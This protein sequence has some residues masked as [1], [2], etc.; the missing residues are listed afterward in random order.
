MA[1]QGNMGGVRGFVRVLWV[2]VL[3]AAVAGC[4]GDDAAP[5]V[6]P[7]GGPALIDAAVA[8]DTVVRGGTIRV[9]ATVQA[10]GF[11]D[12]IPIDFYLVPEGSGDGCGE[13]RHRVLR[14]ALVP[15]DEPVTTRVR[16]A[17]HVTTIEADPAA[18]AV[19]KLTRSALV[20]LALGTGAY[21][22]AAALPGRQA[23]CVTGGRTF[24][25]EEPDAADLMHLSG[26]LANHSFRLPAAV[27][28]SGRHARPAHVLSLSEEV[29]NAGLPVSGPFE[30]GFSLSVQG[31][32]VPLTVEAPGPHGVPVVGDRY[33]F[34][35]RAGDPDGVSIG[36]DDVRGATLHIGLT[37]EAAAELEALSEDTTCDLIATI[38]PDG[39]IQ[40]MDPGN[41][42][43][44]FP[45]RFLV[46]PEAWPL[47]ADAS[48]L[49]ADAS[50]LGD[51]LNDCGSTP[52][53]PAN[54]NLVF[55]FLPTT[56]GA[57]D[58]YTSIHVHSGYQFG[59]SAEDPSY[60]GYG[61]GDVPRSAH[62][63]TAML[64]TAGEAGCDTSGTC[65]TP[66]D[67]L[68]DLT[69]AFPPAQ[70]GGQTVYATFVGHMTTLGATLF[71]TTGLPIRSEDDFSWTSKQIK[72][73]LFKVTVD[74]AGIPLHVDVGAEGQVGLSGTA[75]LSSAADQG[76]LAEAT[77][78]PY[79]Q[80]EAFGDASVDVVVVD[81]GVG[82]NL[83]LLELEPQF[84]LA[85]Q[86]FPGTKNPV[87]I[88]HDEA[89]A[90]QADM[91]V[92]LHTLD[93]DFYA[94]VK[95][96]IVGEKQVPIANWSGLTKSF[97]LIHPVDL[98]IGPVGEFLL[99]TDGSQQSTPWTVWTNQ[100]GHSYHWTGRLA[101]KAGVPYQFDL[102]NMGTVQIYPDDG[103]SGD[104]QTFTCG[105]RQECTQTVTFTKA[106]NYTLEAITNPS[107]Y[108]AGVAEV[109]WAEAGAAD[110]NGL[111]HHSLSPSMKPTDSI[112]TWYYNAAYASNP[113][114]LG[115]PVLYQMADETEVHLHAKGSPN[116]G[117][118]NAPV[119]GLWVQWLGEI[120]FH[121]AYTSPNIVFYLESNPPGSSCAVSDKAYLGLTDAKGNTIRPLQPVTLDATGRAFVRMTVPASGLEGAR[122]NVLY[123]SPD[124]AACS[125][126]PGANLRV[127]VA[128]DG[129]WLFQD[130][131]LDPS[132]N[133]WESELS[134]SM[135]AGPSSASGG[136]L[137]AGSVNS[138]YDQCA[139]PNEPGFSWQSEYVVGAFDFQQAGDYD[140]FVGALSP[141]SY[142]VWIDGVRVASRALRDPY[143]NPNSYPDGADCF[144]GQRFNGNCPVRESQRVVHVEAG[145]HLI[146]ALYRYE[147]QTKHFPGSATTAQSNHLR[148]DPV[149]P[150]QYT[151]SFFKTQDELKGVLHPDPVTGL[152]QETEALLI[153]KQDDPEQ[154]GMHLNWV[155][156]S[157]GYDYHSWDEIEGIYN[158]QVDAE[159]SLGLLMRCQQSGA[160]QPCDFNV[161]FRGKYPFEDQGEYGFST[162]ASEPA[163]P[164]VLDFR[165]DRHPYSTFQTNPDDPQPYQP[166]LPGWFIGV[167]RTSKPWIEAGVND[168]MLAVSRS[169][170][171]CARKSCPNW[172]T[173][174][175]DFPDVVV[176][177]PVIDSTWKQLAAPTDYL[178]YFWDSKNNAT[179]LGE[180]SH[181]TGEPQNFCVGPDCPVINVKIP[182]YPSMPKIIVAASP[183]ADPNGTFFNPSGDIP[184]DVVAFF[185]DAG[186]LCPMS[187]YLYNM[188]WCINGWCTPS[189]QTIAKD[190]P[191]FASKSFH[192]AG[193]A[194]SPGGLEGIF[195]QGA[196]V[197]LMV[198]E[199]ACDCRADFEL[200][201][202]KHC[203]ADT[204][205]YLPGGAAYTAAAAKDACEFS[206]PAGCTLG[207]VSVKAHASKLTGGTCSGPMD[208]CA[209]NLKMDLLPLEHQKTE[210]VT[211]TD[212]GSLEQIQVTCSR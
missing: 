145:Y 22:L 64:V 135:I 8:E 87:G 81:F 104:S 41:Q 168:V 134:G 35:P 140:L 97:D 102:T 115:M 164:T 205:M 107:C 141:H 156:A 53:D 176:Q 121:M 47:P 63:H 21:R 138:T 77:I 92:T 188:T 175:P 51:I 198:L 83:D 19:R 167:L 202:R 38:D 29:G 180:D 69:Y 116:A 61:A 111:T 95:V 42:T 66:L 187:T 120:P 166:L 207:T 210:T 71:E 70:S 179:F 32:T 143:A 130:V 209:F 195:S 183:V 191:S 105:C 123:T 160:T 200:K 72:K 82:V 114:S 211:V 84:N 57:S 163:L 52:P 76:F 100:P 50:P 94:F 199:P 117:L 118:V 20:P 154:S 18:P 27:G 67:T 212:G 65:D 96:I 172:S 155:N 23:Q 170:Q 150:D 159:G 193:E 26:R 99:T 45:V 152:F 62:F 7:A 182:V 73:T 206:I 28:G 190:D 74:C 6:P 44:S 178:A 106:G 201:Y 147:G 30:L 119:Q 16:Q 181:G 127:A 185:P 14:D 13:A 108:A 25:V 124:S 60:F 88:V 5:P 133:A 129:N 85:L 109:T 101:M 93:G 91:P 197:N 48:P 161:L 142:D 89:V 196:H 171:P 148:W 9:S 39:K 149:Q 144:S 125:Q 49:A 54:P 165:L 157:N 10:S 59:S 189:P 137:A 110:V 68:V 186:N 103:H 169:G 79:A 203:F 1:R 4:G 17:F 80:L 24:R 146:E 78:S 177:P 86:Y 173:Q 136:T 204:L 194:S 98:F 75:D 58:S 3:A 162:F 43:A 184:L 126:P 90:I 46:T 192:L 151:L 34:E 12:E 2:I 11:P 174:G 122:F 113:S 31:A 55:C 132:G 139:N 112:E 131:C 158:H 208:E 56:S 36:Q 40:D 37:D 128:L 15:T 153:V 33:V